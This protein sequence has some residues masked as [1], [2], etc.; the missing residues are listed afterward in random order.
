VLTMLAV[1]AGEI[2]EAEF[3]RWIRAHAEMKR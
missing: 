2:A 1:A 3:A